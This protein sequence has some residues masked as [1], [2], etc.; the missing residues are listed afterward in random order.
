M[1]DHCV[2]HAKRMSVLMYIYTAIGLAGKTTKY[3][4]KTTSEKIE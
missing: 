1:H 3:R 4:G 2:P